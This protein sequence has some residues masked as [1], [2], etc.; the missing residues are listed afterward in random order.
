MVPQKVRFRYKLEGRDSDWQDPGTRRQAFYNDLR[1][2]MFT[3]RVLACNNDGIWNELGASLVFNVAPAWF[4][5]TWFRVLWVTS[6]LI[7]LWGIYQLR[8]RSLAKAIGARFDERLDER[9]RMA[10]ELHDTFLQTVQGSKMVADDALDPAS[11]QLRMRHALERLSLW[12]GQAVNEGRAA[13]HAL[14][15]STTE[16]NHLAEFLDR[17]AREHSQRSTISVALTVIGDAKDLHPIVR[18]EIARIAE[19]AIRNACLHSKANQLSIEL[20]YARDLTLSITDN[21]IGIDPDVVE[22]GKAG[23]FGL[24]GMRE[25][26]AR[27]QAKITMKSTLNAGTEMILRVPGNVVYRYEK[28]VF[29]PEPQALVRTS[30]KR[31]ECGKAE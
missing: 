22:M 6:A 26:S 19:E 7:L 5:T 27:I 10:L 15:V 28:D 18:D 31:A 12:L 2:G 25:R 16:R 1:P 3:F 13:L 14:R 8:V 21:G 4:Q 29:S 9:T 20:H 24:Q 17:T 11:D 30:C 23:H